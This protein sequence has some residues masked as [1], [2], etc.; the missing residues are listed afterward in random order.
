MRLLML[1]S[2]V[3]ALVAALPAP[4]SAQRSARRVLVYHDMEG[5]SGQDDWHTFDFDF[6][7]AYA[8][9]RALLVADLN[10]VIAGLF[11]GGATHVDVVDAHGSGN[12][13]PDVPPGALD[14]RARQVFRDT[15]FR[16]YVDLVAPDT[17]DAIVCVGMHAKTGSGGFASHTFA[18]GLDFIVNGASITETELIGYSWG[19]VGVPVVLVTGDDRLRADLRATM[20]WLEYVTVKTST[21]ASSA[22]LRPV[23]EVHRDMRQAAARALR[24]LGARKAMP[25]AGPIRG[26]MRAVPPASF[27]MLRGLPGVTFSG[28]TVVFEAPDFAALY[29]GWMA[30][31]NVASA[32]YGTVLRETVRAEPDADAILLRY[33]ERLTGRW[34]DVESDRWTAPAP[35]PP[36]SR[37]FGAR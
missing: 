27:T 29:D 25:L 19:R 24:E 6:P 16:Q 30:L 36:P 7:E 13:E 17:Y 8:K 31:D 23:E 14:A 10:A 22:Q 1:L 5:L 35:A 32:S 26:G 20:P 12:P 37:F 21:S 4:V 33:N 28:D 3:S 2:A 9:G 11:E 18:P 15:R 34:L